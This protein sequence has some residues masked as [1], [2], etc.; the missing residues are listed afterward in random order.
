MGN[1]GSKREMLLGNEGPPLK[2]ESVYSLA[3]QKND[4]CANSD[5]HMVSTLQNDDSQ[6]LDFT[7]SSKL[8]RE[9]DR[10]FRYETSDEDTTAANQNALAAIRVEFGSSNDEKQATTTQLF[11]SPRHLHQAPAAKTWTGITEDATSRP[12]SEPVVPTDKQVDRDFGGHQASNVVSPCHEVSDNRPSDSGTG[13]LYVSKICRP[14]VDECDED[15][16]SPNTFSIICGDFNDSDDEEARVLTPLVKPRRETACNMNRRSDEQQQFRLPSVSEMAGPDFASTQ[17]NGKKGHDLPSM[18]SGDEAKE[19]V[20]KQLAKILSGHRVA[21]PMRKTSTGSEDSGV[22]MEG[23]KGDDHE[24]YGE[25]EDNLV[26]DFPNGE[27]LKPG[28]Y[29]EIFPTHTNIDTNSSVKEMPTNQLY[30]LGTNNDKDLNRGFANSDTLE[31]TQNSSLKNHMLSHPHHLGNSEIEKSSKCEQNSCGNVFKSGECTTPKTENRTTVDIDKESGRLAVEQQ[32]VKSTHAFKVDIQGKYSRQSVPRRPM[33]PLKR[34]WIR[35]HM[36]QNKRNSFESNRRRGS[37]DGNRSRDGA[38]SP[39]RAYYSERERGQRS[40]GNSVGETRIGI[41]SALNEL[42]QTGTEKEWDSKSQIDEKPSRD[43]EFVYS[44]VSSDG[45]GHYTM[46]NEMQPT[47]ETIPLTANT[48]QIHQYPINEDNSSAPKRF[49][50]DCPLPGNESNVRKINSGKYRDGKHINIRG[51]Y[52]SL[53]NSMPM[54]CPA[55]CPH[56]QCSH[57]DST[58]LLQHSVSCA[59]THRKNNRF[60]VCARGMADRQATSIGKRPRKTRKLAE[61]CWGTKLTIMPR[62]STRL[63]NDPYVHYLNRLDKERVSDKSGTLTYA[64]QNIVG[65]SSVGAEQFVGNTMEECVATVG[66]SGIESFANGGHLTAKEPPKSFNDEPSVDEI[67]SDCAVNSVPGSE[68]IELLKGLIGTEPR[69]VGPVPACTRPEGKPVHSGECTTV[70]IANQN[71]LPCTDSI[72]ELLRNTVN[73]VVGAEENCSTVTLENSI[74]AVLSDSNEHVQSAVPIGA[75][76]ETAN[77]V[78]VTADINDKDSDHITVQTFTELDLVADCGAFETV[79]EDSAAVPISEPSF[80]EE[81]QPE[82]AS[83]GPL[84]Q[85][86]EQEN[87]VDTDIC[88]PQICNLENDYVALDIEIPHSPAAEV[89]CET[90]AAD[91]TK[92]ESD[93]DKAEESRSP[94]LVGECDG[95][96]AGACNNENNEIREVNDVNEVVEENESAGQEVVDSERGSGIQEGNDIDI[97]SEEAE[98]IGQC[99]L[100]NE[101]VSA[102]VVQIGS[103]ECHQLETEVRESQ[104]ETDASAVDTRDDTECLEEA[105]IETALRHAVEIVGETSVTECET[106]VT[107]CIDEVRKETATI[108]IVT[109]GDEPIKDSDIDFY[110]DIIESTNNELYYTSDQGIQ[111]FDEDRISCS[112][113]EREGTKCFNDSCSAG[114]EI[115]LASFGVKDSSVNLRDVSGYLKGRASVNIRRKPWRNMGKSKLGMII[116]DPDSSDSEDGSPGPSKEAA[117]D[118]KGRPVRMRKKSKGCGHH[119]CQTCESYDES[120]VRAL[121]NAIKRFEQAFFGEKPAEENVELSKDI[122]DSLLISGKDSSKRSRKDTTGC[123]SVESFHVGDKIKSKKGKKRKRSGSRGSSLKRSN[124]G[125]QGSDKAIDFEHKSRA[126]EL[127]HKVR[128]TVHDRKYDHR[129]KSDK[130]NLE[131]KSRMAD[132]DYK[133]PKTDLEEKSRKVDFDVKSRKKDSAHK[134]RKPYSDHKSQRREREHKS[135]K[136]H[137]RDKEYKKTNIKEGR[138]GKKRPPKLYSRVPDMYDFKSESGGD[139]TPSSERNIFESLQFIKSHSSSSSHVVDSGKQRPGEKETQQS[140]RKEKTQSGSKDR[141]HAAGKG[142]TQSNDKDKTRYIGKDKTRYIGRDNT[143]SSAKDKTQSSGKDKT[144]KREDRQAKESSRI[145]SPQEERVYKLKE[146]LRAQQKALEDIRLK[147]NHPLPV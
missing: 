102:D 131:N 30:G 85:T 9:A 45:S 53:P 130:A 3:G 94:E 1:E 54:K 88:V 90:T 59:S 108:E 104:K 56:N 27:Y 41:I 14:W 7:K 50:F 39:Y 139:S 52:R 63:D 107:E 37:A 68:A 101:N 22:D 20:K 97:S 34:R 134:S 87:S 112:D 19:K 81:D 32:L 111:E 8:L 11:T 109:E 83:N 43:Q 114:S 66:C 95:L 25:P 69:T 42:Y 92:S 6:P 33:S 51:Y 122:L 133:P 77:T 38:R 23:A 120:R 76:T 115:N 55:V 78:L 72:G 31:R 49:N 146:L 138:V 118:E 24:K 121:I 125:T 144:P 96:K 113:S 74:P 75:V 47:M 62:R 13:L 73:G 46:C 127:G 57:S 132:P 143:Q 142:K 15:E 44:G 26:I 105:L 98:D 86:I 58:E 12:K 18:G 28:K 65:K 135:K 61:L 123:S 64:K 21:F 93:S 99:A 136:K 84:E 80:K 128:K 141:T 117:L 40:L 2:I 36:A 70:D 35:Q 124:S 10:K 116:T 106:L 100:E 140:G 16:V 67:Q 129:Q 110:K 48:Q 5:Y 17:S 89:V 137:K 103:S 4:F 119:A 60:R 71:V 91:D 126:L 29:A 147:S 82:G 145:Q 79:E